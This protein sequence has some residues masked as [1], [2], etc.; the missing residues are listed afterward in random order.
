MTQWTFWGDRQIVSVYGNIYLR[1]F[2]EDWFKIVDT[3]S[4]NVIGEKILDLGCGEGHTTKQILDRLKQKHTCDLL[5]PNESALNSAERF[6]RFEN[7]IGESF[8]E[9]LVSFR[10]NKKYDTVFTSHTN[11]YWA[12]DEQEYRKQLDKVASLIDKGG[13]LMI[14]T[15]PKES[16]HYN[17]MLHQVYPAFNYSGYISNYYKSKGFKVKIIRFKM[18]MFVGD[19]LTNGKFYEVNNFY[20][21]I[22][23]INETPSKKESKEFLEK[24]KKYQKNGY[25]DFK[26]ELIIVSG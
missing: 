15:L 8:V 6:L 23:N 4:K 10:P 16:D 5:E 26:D 25:L 19:M 12:K 18:R 24:L 3:I 9:T 17:I 11:Y 13:R 1:T 2:V 22:H 14:L 7:K 20:K 21:F